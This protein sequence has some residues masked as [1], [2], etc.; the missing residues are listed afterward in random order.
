MPASP[1]W[2]NARYQTLL[3]SAVIA[4]A[5]TLMIRSDLGH[6]HAVSE[7][8][9]QGTPPPARDPNSS[10][11]Y[12]LGQH[13]FLGTHEPGE[14][15]RWIDATQDLV[16]R[17]PFASRDYE[18]DT[19]PTGRPQ[20]LPKAYA[21]WL[22]VVAGGV[23]LV[24]GE[25]FAIA[26]ERTA[27][28]EPVISHALAFAAVVVF[29]GLRFGLAGAAGA[30][31]FFAFFPPVFGQFIPGVLTA[32]TWALL[33]ASYALALHLPAPGYAQ[34][35]SG[36]STRAAIAAAL[37]LWLD[38][39]CGFPAVLVSG[40]AG[41]ATFFR[42]K[43]AFPFL[44]W[45]L[46][47]SGLTFA[48]W[49]IDQAPWAPEAGE[50]RYIHPWYAAAWLG[51]GFA[52]EGAQ[53]FRVPHRSGKWNLT[54]IV[55]GLVFAAPLA[56]VQFSHGYLGWLY[57]SVWMRR[58]ASLDETTVHATAL[59]WIGTASLAET[60]LVLLPI[61]AAIA[62]LAFALKSER[63]RPPGER[64]SYLATAIIFAGLLVLAFFHIRWIAVATLVAAPLIAGW[65]FKFARYKR[66]V[67]GLAALCLVGLIA[68]NQ[69][70]PPAFQ[71]LS[72][73]FTPSAANLDALVYRH[74]S[75]WLA[76][77]TPGQKVSVLAPPEL[78]DSIVFH[79][80]GHVLM[81]TAWESYPGQIAATRVLS[82]PESTE[83]EAVIQSRELTHLVLPSWDKVLPLFVQQP[84]EEGKDTLYARLERWVFPAYL[85]PIPYKLPPI[86]AYAAQNMA[87]FKVTSPQ[88][89]ALQLS[90][91]AEYFVEMERAEPAELVAQVLLRSYSDDPNAAIARA[92]VYAHTK[93][94]SDFDRELGRLAADASAGRSPFSW[95]R[96]VQR[97]IVLALGRQRELARTE[98]AACIDSMTEA[99]LLEL[100]SLQ[101]YHLRNLSARLGL[102]IANEHLGQL[103]AA[104]GAE[105]SSAAAATSR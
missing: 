5:L 103:L 36:G 52:L 57:S 32:K 38:P 45:S 14:T 105:F 34:R 21:A 65:S 28:W 18:K 20:L 76:A 61:V 75:H 70:L 67:V 62:A 79:G 51:L 23:H 7:W 72:A 10:T 24:T 44:R 8:S 11:G 17:G 99:D 69:S 1:F 13:H 56:Y 63:T 49:L 47:G 29:I 43:T 73:K 22:A 35:R 2:R 55:A 83:A 54:M 37:S 97:A 53:R 85:R 59:D 46:I 39:A 78:S 96:R 84:N 91:L 60:A 27:L 77:H 33:L 101:A 93:K 41:I 16:D 94:R 4:V 68:W 31:L 6:L 19:V 86:P 30:G 92:L 98:V 25:P 102:P 9:G 26:V 104:L 100:T 82:A 88:D 12:V 66:A 50:L 95:D 40:A 15:Y 71:R 3:W 74:F 42:Y 80:G 81:S 48:F 89:E 90:R 58:I 64:G 87:V